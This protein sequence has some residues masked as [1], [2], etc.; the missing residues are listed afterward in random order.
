MQ[1]KTIAIDDEPLALKLL[2]DYIDKTPYL[3]LVASFSNPLEAIG[4]LHNEPVDLM[5]LDIQ[6]P[7]ITGVEF[8]R[9]LPHPPKLIF[10]TAFDNYALEG[11]KLNAIDY[12]LK[13][14]NYQEF[15]SASQ[16]AFDLILLEEKAQQ[17]TVEEEHGFLF[18]KSE[19]KLR[20][21][22]LDHILYI[23]GLKDY[24]KVYLAD[25]DKPVLSLS[26]LKSILQKLPE[27]QFMRVHRSYIINLS[28]V[29]TIERGTVLYGDKHIPVSAQYKEAFQAWVSANF[30]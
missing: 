4:F 12:L 6:M 3:K 24:L 29:K 28:Q 26:S 1:I 22:K 11:F 21:I 25:E 27:K 15:L 17:S 30:L 13:P 18:I 10:T 20:R 2:C 9:S 8:A 19:Y 14:F 16:K 5:Y 7:D 23:E